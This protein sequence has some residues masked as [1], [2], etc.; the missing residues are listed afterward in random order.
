MQTVYAIDLIGAWS[1]LT[2]FG[3]DRNPSAEPLDEKKSLY[4]P[5]ISVPLKLKVE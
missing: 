5:R 1:A 3:L 2:N 4:S